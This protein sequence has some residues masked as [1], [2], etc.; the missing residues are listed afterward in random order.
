MWGIIQKKDTHTLDFDVTLTKR[1]DGL[2][3][4]LFVIRCNIKRSAVV[5]QEIIL[6]LLLW[7]SDDYDKR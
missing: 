4:V 1:T 3:Y 2:I 5:G 6:I 7:R